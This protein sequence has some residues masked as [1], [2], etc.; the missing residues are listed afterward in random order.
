MKKTILDYINLFLLAILLI[1]TLLYFATFIQNKGGEKVLWT[2]IIESNSGNSSAEKSNT[3]K[4]I[5]AHFFNSFNNSEFNLDNE[6][7]TMTNS[8]NQN[9][10]YFESNADLLPDSFQLKY[11]SID[12]R[13]F[14]LLNTPIPYDKILNSAKNNKKLAKLY[15]EIFPNGKI[16]L[17]FDQ[18]NSERKQLS[19]FKAKEVQGNLDLLVFRKSSGQLYNDFEDLLNITDFSDLFQNQYGWI[20]KIKMENEGQLQRINTYS[21]LDESIDDVEDES[22]IEKRNI[23]KTFRIDWK[24]NQEY[25]VQYHFSPNEILTA[26]RKLNEIKS[27]EPI[28]ISFELAPNKLPTCKISKGGEVIPLKNLYPELPVEYAD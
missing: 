25:G 9:K 4:I 18:E 26:F 15:L 28:T 7:G 21:F 24:D 16:I 13:K 14:Y 2:A 20:C 11:F 10:I 23:P 6:S 3:I 5:D 22:K 12:E 19:T 8:K 1:L 17:T 27:S